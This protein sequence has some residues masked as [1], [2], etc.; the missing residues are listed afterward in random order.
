MEWE[1]GD[2]MLI[3]IFEMV[4]NGLQKDDK[5]IES[6]KWRILFKTRNNIA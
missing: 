1:F 3:G 2:V 4:L 5:N 6:K